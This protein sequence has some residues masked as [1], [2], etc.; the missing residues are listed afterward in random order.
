[1]GVATAPG[2]TVIAEHPPRCRYM[3]LADKKP[4]L[5]ATR[6]LAS[7]MESGNPAAAPGAECKAT[8]RRKLDEIPNAVGHSWRKS[9]KAM[10]E[11]AKSRH[12]RRA[13]LSLGRLFGP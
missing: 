13:E 2:S 7:L 1:M 10:M 5:W 11:R 4:D 9:P 3:L 12:A 6:K 8:S